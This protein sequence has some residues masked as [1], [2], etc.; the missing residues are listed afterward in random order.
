MKFASDLLAQKLN[1]EKNAWP[2]FL[3]ERERG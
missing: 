3:L 1:I 2:P